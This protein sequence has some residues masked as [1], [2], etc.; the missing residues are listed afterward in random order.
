[1]V[2]GDTLEGDDDE[3]DGDDDIVDI[4]GEGALEV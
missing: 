2:Q 1:M 4:V 3:D